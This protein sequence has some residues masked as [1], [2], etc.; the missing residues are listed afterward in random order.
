MDPSVRKGIQRRRD[1]IRR[2]PGTAGDY[3]RL[4]KRDRDKV[5][6]LFTTDRKL[7][8]NEVTRLVEDLTEDRL[9]KRRTGNLRDRALA[10]LRRLTERERYRDATVV[11]N[12]RKMSA[13]QLRTATASSVDDLV[14]LARIQEEGNPFWYH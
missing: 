12:V 14:D 2:Y 7:K 4:H 13:G 8:P 6:D 3:I 10:S 9:R 1:W 5:D 11:K